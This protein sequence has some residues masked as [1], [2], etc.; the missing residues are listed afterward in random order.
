MVPAVLPIPRSLHVE[1]LLLDEDGLTILASA[2]A[3]DA[4][5]P[6]CGQRSDRVHSRYARTLADLPWAG[7]AVR[8]RVH[9]RKFFCDNATCRRRIFPERLA[10]VVAVSARRTDRQ[11]KS[12]TA[13]AFALGG[14]AGA[15]LAGRLGMPVSWL[16]AASSH[17]PILRARPAMLPTGVNHFVAR[18]VSRTGY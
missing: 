18:F 11:R 9:V 14:E 5:C 1:T 4:P 17:G 13:I 8:L 2:K 10:D 6:R 15:R 3:T 12:L 16:G 7:V